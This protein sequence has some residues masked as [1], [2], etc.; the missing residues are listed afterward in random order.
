[1]QRGKLAGGS[2]L[3]A[4]AASP[5]TIVQA[6]SRCWARAVEFGAA[7]I[8]MMSGN[9]TR[10]LRDDAQDSC[11]VSMT[12]G[13]GGRVAPSGS[14]LHRRT[15]SRRL[16]SRHSEMDRL[17]RNSPQAVFS[18]TGSWSFGPTFCL[19]SASDWRIFQ[20]HFVLGVIG[21]RRHDLGFRPLFALLQH[22]SLRPAGGRQSDNGDRFSLHRGGAVASVAD[23]GSIAIASRPNTQQPRAF[24]IAPETP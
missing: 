1:M 23:G 12:C 5:K 15:I 9:P 20:N 3:V 19:T 17:F 18:R 24:P 10:A 21:R 13:S 6:L 14:G 8:S 4:E 22:P 16:S 7:D 2:D 11:L